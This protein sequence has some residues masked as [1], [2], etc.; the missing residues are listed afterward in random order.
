MYAAVLVAVLSEHVGTEVIL[1]SQLWCI[2]SVSTD[3]DIFIVIFIGSRA[4]SFKRPLLS[5]DVN[6]RLCVCLWVR[7]FEVKYLENQRR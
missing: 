3:T 5:V 7:N 1:L 4:L 2:S 6:V